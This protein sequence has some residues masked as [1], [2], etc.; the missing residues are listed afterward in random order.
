[1]LLYTDLVTDEYSIG[2]LGFTTLCRGTSEMNVNQGPNCC[3]EGCVSMILI[4]CAHARWMMPQLQS[5]APYVSVRIFEHRKCFFCMV[6]IARYIFQSRRRAVWQTIVVVCSV[7]MV[8]HMPSMD[9]VLMCFLSFQLLEPQLASQP[10]CNEKL[11]PATKSVIKQ[12]LKGDICAV[13]VSTL[14]HI[15]NAAVAV[16]S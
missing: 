7:C 3:C 4:V 14:R 11:A 13:S 8:C 16:L 2:L 1:M 12:S 10:D 5:S 15:D 6:Q 9:D